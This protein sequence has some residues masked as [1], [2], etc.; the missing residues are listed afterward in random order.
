LITRFYIFVIGRE[1][2]DVNFE[3]NECITGNKQNQRRQGRLRI[4]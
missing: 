1:S 4:T 2:K 3:K